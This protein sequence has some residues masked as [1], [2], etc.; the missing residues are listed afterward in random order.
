MKLK[1]GKLYKI[2]FLDHCLGETNG[3]ITCTICGWYIKSTKYDH[4]FSWWRVENTEWEE[5]NREYV[6]LIQSTILQVEEIP[7]SVNLAK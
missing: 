5:D 6:N 2:T 3:T 7:H 1:Q 4:I